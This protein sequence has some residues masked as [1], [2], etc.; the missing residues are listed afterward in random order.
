MPTSTDSTKTML[1]AEIG[2]VGLRLAELLDITQTRAN[3]PNTRYVYIA[4]PSLLVMLAA[5]TFLLA[6][7]K[8]IRNLLIIILAVVIVVAL[9]QRRRVGSRDHEHVQEQERGIGPC[10]RFSQLQDDVDAPED[11]SRDLDIRH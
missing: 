11:T 9:R 2:A 10:D 6:L 5:V 3:N 7:L 4:I 1:L 8:W